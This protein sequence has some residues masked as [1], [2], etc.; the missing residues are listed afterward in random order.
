M[1]RNRIY[2]NQNV[3]QNFPVIRL[4]AMVWA[5][6]PS[7]NDKGWV[8]LIKIADRIMLIV[9]RIMSGGSLIKY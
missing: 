5:S 4:I 8:S 3:K 2:E 9:I 1:I 7:P 6:R